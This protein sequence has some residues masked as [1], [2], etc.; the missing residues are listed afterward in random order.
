MQQVKIEPFKLI[1]I[2]VR[3]TNANNQAA[4]DI[5]ALWQRFMSENTL[6]KIPNKVDTT[7]YAIYTDYE[8]DHNQPY[9]TLIGCSVES[10]DEIPD[11]MVGKVVD[12]GAYVKSSAKGDVTKIVAEEWMKIW[13]TTLNRAYTADFEVYGEKAQNP[14]DAEVDFLIAV[15]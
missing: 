6:A 2:D 1:G 3:T 11:G 10:L 7:I 13:G 14:L 8:G 12:G 9:T 5:G 15:N 4:E